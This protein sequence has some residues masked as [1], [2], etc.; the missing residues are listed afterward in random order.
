MKSDTGL[1]DV[2]LGFKL[3]YWCQLVNYQRA[4]DNSSLA[5]EDEWKNICFQQLFGPFRLSLI[6]QLNQSSNRYFI[7]FSIYLP[8]WKSTPHFLII[9]HQEIKIISTGIKMYGPTQTSQ[10]TL[11]LS[12]EEKPLSGH[13]KRQIIPKF[14]FWKFPNI[15][16]I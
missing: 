3:K 12:F 1:I 9:L 8:C 13:G 7:G 5:Y 15:C 14:E 2:V 10:S 6:I 11:W 4:K 16:R